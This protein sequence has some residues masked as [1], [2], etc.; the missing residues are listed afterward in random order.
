MAMPSIARS[1][2]LTLAL[3]ASAALPASAA[4][5]TS[6]AVVTASNSSAVVR[7]FTPAGG[8]L[9]SIGGGFEAYTDGTFGVRVAMGD[10]N[11]DGVSD[12]VTARR[13][14]AAPVKVFSGT[15]GL[16]RSFF[17]YG[18]NYRLGVNVAAGDVTGDGR[19]DIVTGLRVGS[20]TVKVFDGA[21]GARVRSFQ[22]Y[23][24]T[25]RHG[26][27][28]AAGDLDGDGKAE[29]VTGT[30]VG[31][32]NVRV[33][34]GATGAMVESFLA[35]DP[36]FTAG[37][38]VAVAPGPDDDGHGEIVT[39]PGKGGTPT[40]KVFDGETLAVSKS[41]LAFDP[42]FT[43]GVDV[44]AGMADGDGIADIVAG[45]ASRGSQVKVFDGRTIRPVIGVFSPM[46]TYLGSV[47]GV[48]VAFGELP[49]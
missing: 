44:A 11:A 47:G 17:P 9:G 27:N 26:V 21:T 13:F 38:N 30:A 19:A 6:P 4:A 18:A 32:S 49:G 46:P 45:K 31:S 12:F 16:M 40:V 37:V 35:Y 10:V 28:V 43:G 22:A 24:A 2:A 14:F 48:S 5:T 25:F 41:F 33:F 42:T 20:P 23:D 7:A 1:F 34:S 29:I 39:G 15:G 3:T 36:A 8:L